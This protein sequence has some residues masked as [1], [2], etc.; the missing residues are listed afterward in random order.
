MSG[1]KINIGPRPSSQPKVQVDEWVETRGSG[2]KMK[3]L[4]VDIPESIHRTM[5][6]DCAMKG[7]KI[8]DVIRELLS[9]RFGKL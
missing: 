3:R 6:A 1:K 9:E 7:L 8:A 2:E 5:K 4:T